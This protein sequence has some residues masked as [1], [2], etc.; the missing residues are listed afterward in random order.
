MVKASTTSHYFDEKSTLMK[1][2]T[3]KLMTFEQDKQSPSQHLE[4][5]KDKVE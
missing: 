4:N 1:V 2:L 5:N 3:K